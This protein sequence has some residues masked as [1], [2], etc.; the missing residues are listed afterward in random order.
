MP[1]FGNDV[2]QVEPDPEQFPDHEYVYEPV[3][4]EALAVNVTDWLV[5][6][7]FGEAETWRDKGL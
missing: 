6:A 7:G 1:A 3:P 5:L 4:P 2:W